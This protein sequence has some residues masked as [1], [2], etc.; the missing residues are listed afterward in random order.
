[1]PV[2]GCCAAKK[3]PR[4]ASDS[5]GRAQVL[6]AG[7]GAGAGGGAVVPPCGVGAIVP[8][9]FVV[10]GAVAQPPP[11]AHPPVAHP[12]PHPQLLEQPPPHLPQ[13]DRRHERK[14]PPPPHELTPQPPPQLRRQQRA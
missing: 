8:S 3:A 7:A 12:P 11:T 14:Q 4:G 13:R 5:L 2:G 9:G 1:M 6:G 10:I